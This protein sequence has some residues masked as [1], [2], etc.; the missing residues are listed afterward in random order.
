MPEPLPTLADLHLDD[1]AEATEI[2]NLIDKPTLQALLNTIARSA[3]RR[4]PSWSPVSCRTRGSSARPVARL[5]G[6]EQ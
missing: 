3:P 1:A 6:H 4:P 2:L 5:Q